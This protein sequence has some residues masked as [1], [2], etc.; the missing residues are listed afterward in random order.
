MLNTADL[1]NARLQQIT[2]W[3]LNINNGRPDYPIRFIFARGP[4]KFIYLHLRLDHWVLC[5]PLVTFKTPVL[6][7]GRLECLKNSVWRELLSTERRMFL[8]KFDTDKNH[9]RFDCNKYVF[10]NNIFW[11][12]ILLASHGTRLVSVPNC[13]FFI[14][15][16]LSIIGIWFVAEIIQ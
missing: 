15:D 16:N 10:N 7:R 5:R 3:P 8:L 2:L 6:T 1:K 4:G 11:E 14:Y 13:T 9:L 12:R